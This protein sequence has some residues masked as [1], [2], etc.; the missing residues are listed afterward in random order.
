[1]E[2]SHT[3][4]NDRYHVLYSK[5]HVRIGN[6]VAI[7]LYEVINDYKRYKIEARYYED[8]EDAYEMRK[9]TR[10]PTHVC[11]HIYLSP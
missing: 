10:I 5:L 2:A 3:I 4:M 1:M 6:K 8:G 9:D 7:R 11:Y